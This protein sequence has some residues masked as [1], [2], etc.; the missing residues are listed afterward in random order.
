MPIGHQ[1]EKSEK[2]SEEK[3]TEKNTEKPTD[4]NTEQPTDK[5]TEQ[6]PT[7]NTPSQGSTEGTTTQTDGKPPAAASLAE[8]EGAKTVVEDA[9]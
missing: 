4:K 9:K 1:L 8:G 2:P 6:P 3:P 7:S 5:N